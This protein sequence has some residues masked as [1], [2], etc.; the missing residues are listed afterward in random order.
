M[1]KSL[2]INSSSYA[3]EL[4]LPYIAPAILAADSIQNKYI[5]LHEGVKFKAVIKK[6]SGG[7]IQAAA[8]D[9]TA[10]SGSLDLDEVVLTVTNLMVNEQLC[11][12]DFRSDWEAKST[13]SG[14]I[15]DVV[16]AKFEDFL[17]MYLAAKVAEGIEYN[18]WQGKYDYT[19]GGTTG[20]IANNFDS[21]LSRIV[22]ASPAHE[23][24]AAGAFTADANATT[25]V[26]THLDALVADMPDAIMNNINTVI[27][28]SK[29]TQYLLLRAMAGIIVTSGGVSPT[30]VAS[31]LPTQYMGHPIVVPA[32]FPNDTLL[33]TTPD[34]LHFGTDL[35]SDYNEAKV[36]DTSLT[37]ADDNVR[38]AMRFVGGTQVAIMNDLAVVRRSS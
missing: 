6:L 35:V 1:A 36:V 20:L 19:D 18:L 26:L 32:G 28:M 17:L 37:L 29:K 24:L 23:T 30:A 33:A 34:N 21:I 10:P 38:V 8:C 5:T 15:N 11:K 16:P 3:G 13:G 31:P 25:G 9:F 27:Y 22:A 4:A 7:T 14:F 2:D 12:A